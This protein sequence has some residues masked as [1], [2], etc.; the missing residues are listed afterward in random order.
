MCGCASSFRER[1]TPA[2]SRTQTLDGELLR[3]GT[4]RVEFIVEWMAG[5]APERRALDAL[6]QLAE[7]YG[8][9]PAGW[10]RRAKGERIELERDASYVFV[11]YV[12]DQLEGFGLAY[13]TFVRGRTIHVIAINQEA[14]RRFRIL[15][16][17]HRLEQQ[18]LV[19]EYGH[20][21]GLPTSDHGY[22]PHYP[23]PAG[24]MH[25][26]N[27]DCALSLPRWR[28][29]VY[30]AFHVAFGREYLEDYC[31]QCREAID[32]FQRGSE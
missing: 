31:E 16:P 20:L 27:P 13:E 12:G 28:A 3:P 15:V 10:R 25:C 24:G 30:S 19:H 11:K 14:H 6:V 18:T 1:V 22:Y 4:S 23:D 7:R 2:E 17:Q 8:G 5:R 21:L 9:R 29:L 32:R 26:V